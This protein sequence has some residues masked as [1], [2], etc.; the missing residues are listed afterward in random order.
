[1]EECATVV[2]FG[3]LSGMVPNW[4]YLNDTIKRRSIV[5]KLLYVLFSRSKKKLYLIS[6][7]GRCTS[8]RQKY[9]PTDELVEIDFEYDLWP[10]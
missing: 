10:R 7:Q 1:M 9:T 8:G 4:R 2:A 5:F 3:L 6:E